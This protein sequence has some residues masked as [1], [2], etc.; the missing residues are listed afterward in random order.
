MVSVSDPSFLDKKIHNVVIDTPYESMLVSDMALNSFNNAISFYKG[1]E[2]N[3]TSMT[4][5]FPP[6]RAYTPQEKKEELRKRGFD[7]YI[8]IEMLNQN[9]TS[10]IVG[11]SSFGSS[12]T[13]GT[14]NYNMYQSGNNYYGAGSGSYTT[15]GSSTTIPIVAHNKSS[16]IRVTMFDIHSE[17]LIWFADAQTDAG[18]ALYMDDQYTIDS[19]IMKVVSKLI[20]DKH[21]V[22]TYGQNNNDNNVI[23]KEDSELIKSING[24][25]DSIF[26]PNG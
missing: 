5:Q 24:F 17:A 10:Q 12:T 21:I 16:K 11:A 1:S 15:Y 6:T 14:S 19:V 4:K 23:E 8:S 7:S 26:G 18:G 25:V 3:A 9:R 20:E 13:S 22:S 2:I